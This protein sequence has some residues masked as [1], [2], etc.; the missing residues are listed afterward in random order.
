MDWKCNLESNILRNDF[1][2]NILRI[3]GLEMYALVMATIAGF[4]FSAMESV[5]REEVKRVGFFWRLAFGISTC[6]SF[7][8]SLYST[9]IFALSSLYAKTALG[10]HKDI[11]YNAF[12]LRTQAS[13]FFT[14]VGKI[15]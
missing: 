8:L 12:L 7:V 2:R 6:L 5:T 11:E 15:L 3:D 10:L 4:S 14:L 9:V 1:E 13:D